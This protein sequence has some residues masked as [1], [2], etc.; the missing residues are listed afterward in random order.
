M[1]EGEMGLISYV[2]NGKDTVVKTYE[3]GKDGIVTI[4]CKW[5]EHSGQN[6]SESEIF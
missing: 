5:Q 2:E 3:R 1:K 4:H 6:L